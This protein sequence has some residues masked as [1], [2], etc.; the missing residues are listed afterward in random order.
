MTVIRA[1]DP[2]ILTLDVVTNTF[3]TSREV[4]LEAASLT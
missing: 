1:N 4:Y 3:R 2:V